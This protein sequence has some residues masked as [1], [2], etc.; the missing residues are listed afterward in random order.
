MDAKVL[1]QTQRFLGE[2]GITSSRDG[3]GC[4]YWDGQVLLVWLELPEL[5]TG[6][7]IGRCG[8]TLS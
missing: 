8:G 3:R 2:P 1:H 4:S 6:R 5:A 7:H